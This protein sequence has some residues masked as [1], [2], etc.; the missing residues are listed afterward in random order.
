MMFDIRLKHFACGLAFLAASCVPPV[1]AEQSPTA[2]LRLCSE[3]KSLMFKGEYME[4]LALLNQWIA[5]GERL[6]MAYKLR[7]DTYTAMQKYRNAI[8]DASMAIILD[9]NFR[10]AYAARA[11][12]YTRMGDYDKAIESWHQS[13]QHLN[14]DSEKP[15]VLLNDSIPKILSGTVTDTT[16]SKGAWE[17]T[18]LGWIYTKKSD[19]AAALRE[20]NEAISLEPGN[21]TEAHFLS[22]LVYEYQ[23]QLK[24]ALSEFA[25]A[26][27]QDP[28]LISALQHCAIL[29][30]VLGYKQDAASYNTLLAALRPNILWSRRQ[31][32]LVPDKLTDTQVAAWKAAD[33]KIPQS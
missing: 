21:C 7:S 32:V 29:S 31:Y 12:A 25:K 30:E 33:K 2:F 6:A 4:S 19:F 10:L 8:E 16:A 23:G 3:Q 14:A 26:A 13:L 1:L 24:E 15:G 27:Q 11:T 17:H 5:T 18:N 20:Y 28:Y 9:P 22:G